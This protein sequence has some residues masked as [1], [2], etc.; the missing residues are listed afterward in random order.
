M[1]DDHTIGRTE[2]NILIRRFIAIIMDFLILSV[3]A[4]ILFVFSPLLS[5]L[6]QETAWKSELFGFILLVIPVFLY[7]FLFEASC[8]KATPGK[9]CLHLRVVMLDGTNIGYKNSFYR[10][11]VKFIPWEI[12]HFAIWQFMFPESM[13][14]FI[15]M[16]LL[17]I[18]N[19]FGILYIVFPFFNSKKRAIHDF[20]AHSFLT[21]R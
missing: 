17:V 7:F 21:M 12:A 5:P 18:S 11:A 10:S 3:Y 2:R 6:F 19:I 16:T 15:A 13:F 1:N 8:L 20:A 14:S 9:V 4:V